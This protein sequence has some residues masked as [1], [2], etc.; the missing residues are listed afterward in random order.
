MADSAEQTAPL[1]DSGPQTDIRAVLARAADFDAAEVVNLVGADQVRRWRRGERVPVETYLLM[2]P[3][4]PANH[5]DAFEL[6]YNEFLLR[7][8]L[9]E[10]PA[11]TE[12]VWR[13]PQFEGRLRRQVGLHRALSD[14]DGRAPPPPGQADDTP[15]DAN[16]EAGP[17]AVAPT[18]RPAVCG[19]EIRSELG[20]GGMGVV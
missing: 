6:V 13:F 4:L 17:T 5:P 20:R 10:V 8:E 9:G 11:L 19:Y 16:G 1:P 14:D 7:E 2:H 12:F 15:P 3:A 18:P